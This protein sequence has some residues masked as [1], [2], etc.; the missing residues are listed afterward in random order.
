VVTPAQLQRGCAGARDGGNPLAHIFTRGK[1]S[2]RRS[3]LVR[4]AAIAVR[5]ICWLQFD[6]CSQPLMQIELQ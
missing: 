6:T 2:V 5:W 4:K 1:R 3:L